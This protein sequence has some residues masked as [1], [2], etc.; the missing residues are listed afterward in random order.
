MR[1]PGTLFDQ[2]SI[3]CCCTFRTVLDYYR[4]FWTITDYSKLFWTITDYL[5]RFQMFTDFY[6]LLQTFTAYFWLLSS[7]KACFLLE[8]GDTCSC[9]NRRH[10]FCLN[11]H[12]SLLVQQNMFSCWPS[13]MSF[14]STRRHSVLLSKKMLSGNR[15]KHVCTCWLKKKTCR[16]VKRGDMSYIWTRRQVCVSEL[17]D[18]PLL[19]S[20]F[21]IH[22]DEI[23]QK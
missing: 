4:Q 11:E 17:L 19:F 7:E 14:C 16:P 2:W 23:I 6:G 8:Q 10:V 15:T 3:N 22:L 12:T 20:T 1:F 13:N 5:R 21:P 9:S 18:Y